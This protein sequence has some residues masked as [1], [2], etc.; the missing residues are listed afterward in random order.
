M[1]DVLHLHFLHEHD[2]IV[3]DTVKQGG[4]DVVVEAEDGGEEEEGQKKTG[5][6]LL[7]LSPTVGRKLKFR[8]SLPHGHR[9]PPTPELPVGT[10][11]LRPA[12]GHFERCT[13]RAAAATNR[14]PRLANGLPFSFSY[15]RMGD[16]FM[17]VMAPCCTVQYSWILCQCRCRC[18]CRCQC[19]Y[20]LPGGAL[21][22]RGTVQYSKA[23][24]R[25]PRYE[26]HSACSILQT[27][28]PQL[29]LRDRQA[30]LESPNA[31]ASRL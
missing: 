16:S 3:R 2:C 26:Y 17:G 9:F 13:K 23:Q 20:A 11:P 15:S 27:S 25:V 30:A 1:A 24:H 8:R 22:P 28:P 7:G 29:E 4:R 31:P 18:R 21:F 6:E 12:R 14:G 10:S 19:Q 5:G